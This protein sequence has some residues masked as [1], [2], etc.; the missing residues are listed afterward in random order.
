MVMM[1][2]FSMDSKPWFLGKIVRTL[3]CPS[4]DFSNKK[5]DFHNPS[6]SRLG[7]FT[8]IMN[9]GGF[10]ALF[11]CKIFEPFWLRLILIL[12]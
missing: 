12:A 2:V 1:E 4:Y 10:S 7:L 8:A 3:K 6:G 11:F 5:L 9:L